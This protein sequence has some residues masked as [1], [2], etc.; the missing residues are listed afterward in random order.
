MNDKPPVNEFVESIYVPQCVWPRNIVLVSGVHS[1]P[2]ESSI[3]QVN[4]TSNVSCAISRNMY[5]SRTKD[6]HDHSLLTIYKLSFY[7]R[8]LLFK[9]N[10]GNTWESTFLKIKINLF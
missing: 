2:V 1:P 6:T 9:I 10:F 5:T 8:H 4:A 3:D 7:A